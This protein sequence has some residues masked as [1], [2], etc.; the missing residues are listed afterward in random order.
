MSEQDKRIPDWARQERER[1]M[2]WI[3][4]YLEPFWLA[5]AIAYQDVGRGAIV[6]DTTIQIPGAGHPFAYAPLADLEDPDYKDAKRMAHE[7]TPG[8]E[9]VVALLKEHERIST[10][11]IG[12]QQPG[13]QG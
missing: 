13:A 10:Y 1:D 3:S 12:L 6:V 7:Y 5:A 9:V 4:E 2:E 8:R 11:R